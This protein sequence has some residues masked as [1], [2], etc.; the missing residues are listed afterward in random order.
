M[1][2]LFH[3]GGKIEK[4]NNT[5]VFRQFNRIFSFPD[6]DIYDSV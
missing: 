4:D 5:W 3:L 2:T 6:T 1:P